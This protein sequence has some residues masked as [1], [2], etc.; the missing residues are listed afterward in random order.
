MSGP[1]VE[2][3]GELGSWQPEDVWRAYWAAPV[4]VAC[5][6]TY[7]TNTLLSERETHLW[8]HTLQRP[9]WACAMLAAYVAVAATLRRQVPGPR[10][11]LA[12]PNVWIERIDRA[13]APDTGVQL[14]DAFRRGLEA[15]GRRVSLAAVLRPVLASVGPSLHAWAEAVTPPNAPAPFP[16]EDVEAARA[17]L[18][19]AEAF[20]ATYW[21]RES[22]PLDTG[23]LASAMVGVVHD[24]LN[25]AGLFTDP[26]RS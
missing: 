2:L 6:V 19:F 3:R 18:A 17:H 15:D 5:L 23:E 21:A 20:Q 4:A 13:P 25:S 22:A 9:V 16:E 7:P 11:V 8:A 26:W 10:V 14:V 12:G 1:P 24:A